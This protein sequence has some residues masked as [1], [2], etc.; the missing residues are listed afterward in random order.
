MVSAASCTMRARIANQH[1]CPVG[2][3]SERLGSSALCFRPKVSE[4]M[5]WIQTVF[6][7][8]HAAPPPASVS[9]AIA[10]FVGG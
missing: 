5:P 2:T 3:G 6:R 4:T 10:G 8:L 1:Q 7:V 9:R